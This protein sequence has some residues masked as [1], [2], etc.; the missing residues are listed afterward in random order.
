MCRSAVGR[1]DKLKVHEVCPCNPPPPPPLCDCSV[2]RTSDRH[3]STCGYWISPPTILWSFIVTVLADCL[4]FC[5]CLRAQIGPSCPVLCYNFNW[6]TTYK[7]LLSSC[8]CSLVDS[9]G[10]QKH[11]RPIPAMV[12]TLNVACHFRVAAKSKSSATSISQFRLASIIIR[13]QTG[14]TLRTCSTYNIPQVPFC[15]LL[16]HSVRLLKQKMPSPA[17]AAVTQLIQEEDEKLCNPTY[18]VWTNWEP[19]NDVLKV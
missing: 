14:T 16:I 18:E 8:C 12:Q 3:T 17:E 9:F 7:P 6:N 2:P 13:S 11:S 1:W 4:L 19:D 15:T 10:G 5:S